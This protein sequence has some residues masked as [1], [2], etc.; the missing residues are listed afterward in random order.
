MTLLGEH[1]WWLP[2]V[3]ARLPRLNLVAEGA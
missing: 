3:F 1:N 2:R